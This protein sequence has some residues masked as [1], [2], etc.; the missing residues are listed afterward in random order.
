MI[1]KCER[2][3]IWIQR[4]HKEQVIKVFCTS[5]YAGQTEI[6]DNTPVSEM[7]A[8]YKAILWPNTRCVSFQTTRKCCWDSIS[9]SYSL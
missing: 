3:H 4:D 7:Q 9:S 2:Q 8:A 6:K 5:A 1:C